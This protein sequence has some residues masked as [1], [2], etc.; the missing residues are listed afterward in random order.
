VIVKTLF[1]LIVPVRVS[2]VIALLNVPVKIQV[3]NHIGLLPLERSVT[4]A[5]N[6]LIQLVVVESNVTSD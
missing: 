3:V 2:V 4:G 5:K 1:A 6:G